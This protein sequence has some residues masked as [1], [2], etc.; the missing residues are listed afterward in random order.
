[1]LILL[2]IHTVAQG[3]TTVEAWVPQKVKLFVWLVL[4]RRLWTRHRHGLQEDDSCNLC[5]QAP[6]T[7][8]HLLLH[9]PVAKEVLWHT[10]SWAG[11]QQWF[12]T[13]SSEIMET[14]S[15]M[16]NGLPNSA[17]K[18]T[19]TIL[20]CLRVPLEGK[21]P[22][23]VQSLAFDGPTDGGHATIK[24]EAQLRIAASGATKWVV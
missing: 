6:E 3:A 13:S 16:R 4:H 21:K 7:T 22:A 9:C 10:L 12:P 1:M 18:G 8:E 23:H 19:D 20:A 24:E 15:D 17:R 2:W 11:L 14:W 5:D